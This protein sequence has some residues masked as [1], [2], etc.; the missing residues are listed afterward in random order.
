[1]LQCLTLKQISNTLWPVL[2]YWRRTEGKSMKTS[3][4]RS[5]A[6]TIPMSQGCFLRN[7]NMDQTMYWDFWTLTICMALQHIIKWTQQ[8]LCEKNF[9][10]GLVGKKRQARDKSGNRALSSSSFG[11]HPHYPLSFAAYFPTKVLL[12]LSPQ[13][14]CLIFSSK[15]LLDLF[16]QHYFLIFPLKS[17]AWSF[18]LKVRLDLSPE[19]YCLI[20]PTKVPLD[21]SPQK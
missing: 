3:K 19:K 15:V 4:N 20:F 9:G 21:P 12:D 10:P 8:P 6:S 18:P 5:H 7:V 16:P 2:E 14:Y 11:L 17:T 1:M 13:K